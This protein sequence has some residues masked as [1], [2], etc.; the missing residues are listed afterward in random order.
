MSSSEYDEDEDEDEE[1]HD[2]ERDYDDYTKLFFRG[3]KDSH[4]R[5]S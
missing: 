5:L 3:A 1:I 2:Q 4:F